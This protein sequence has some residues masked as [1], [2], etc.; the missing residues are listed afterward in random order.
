MFERGGENE[1]PSGWR[2]STNV[3]KDQQLGVKLKWILTHGYAQFRKP[4]SSLINSKA[5]AN[6]SYSQLD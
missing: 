4:V 1:R 6:Y 5:S 2:F 3:L